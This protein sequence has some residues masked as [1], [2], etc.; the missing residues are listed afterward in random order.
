MRMGINVPNDLLRRVREIDLEVNISQVCREAL[1]WKVDFAV[2]A[3]ALA[4]ED[5]IAIE[6]LNGELGPVSLGPDWTAMAYE[7]ARAWLREVTAEQWRRFVWDVEFLR[8]RGERETEM[9]QSWSREVEGRGLAQRVWVDWREWLIE[10]E[11]ALYTAGVTDV[12]LYRQAREEYA[13]AW[14]AYVQAAW[15]LLDERRQAEYDR[16]KAESLQR[17]RELWAPEAPEQ[18]L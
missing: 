4:L 18:L 3:S 17:R 11:D 15:K 1:Q 12:N 5:A 16:L 10:Q 14:F 6:R 9:V 13:A 7:D 2:R 8:R